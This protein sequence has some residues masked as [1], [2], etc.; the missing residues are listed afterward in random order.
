MHLKELIAI[1]KE[2]RESNNAL[3]KGEGNTPWGTPEHMQGFMGDVGDLAKLVMAKSGYRTY[4]DLD[5]KLAHELSDCLWSVM[6]IADEL[7][8]D[9]EQAFLHTMEELRRRKAD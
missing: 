8:V 9:L 6:I 3:T 5:K 2:I 4:D 7:G 1:A